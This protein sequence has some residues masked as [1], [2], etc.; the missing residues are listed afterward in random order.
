MVTFSSYVVRHVDYQIEI[1]PSSFKMMWKLQEYPEGGEILQD[2][3]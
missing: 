2:E 3:A 1:Y